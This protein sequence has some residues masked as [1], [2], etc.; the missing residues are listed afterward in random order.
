MLKRVVVTGLGCVTPLGIS[1]PSTWENLIAGACGISRLESEGIE[2]LPCQI[3]G[4][5][6]EFD[7]SK[8]LNANERRSANRTTGFAMSA[9]IEAT[10]Q[11]SLD[12]TDIDCDR[13]GVC[14]GSSLAGFMETILTAR[15]VNETQKRGYRRVS[16]FFV[17]RILDNMAAGAIAMRLGLLGPNHSCG[18]ACT[19]GAHS[20]GDGYNLIRLGMADVM[21]AGS[22]EACLHPLA[23]SGFS[24]AK[25]LC[26]DSNE[27]PLQSSRPFDESRS[28]FVMS[29]GAA[30]LVLEEMEHAVNR[31]AQIL[32]EVAGY[33]LSADAHH[34][35]APH[36]EGRG[37]LNA[38][39][40]ALQDVKLSRVSYINAH[41]TSTPL[42]DLAEG[43]A[44]RK[45]FNLDHEGPGPYVS[46]SKGSL[47]HLLGGAGS[48]E[49]LVCVQSIVH[50]TVPH[51]LNLVEPCCELNHVTTPIKD[52]EVDHV[53]TNSFGFGGTNASLLFKRFS[54]GS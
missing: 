34:I 44:I 15:S 33:G 41:A 7:E 54:G 22:A 13:A 14:F 46:S 43:T 25:A 36:P 3:G 52:A 11:A 45:I 39:R 49:A 4:S 27:K 16:P 19:T 51:T 10:N 28:G 30:V 18:T 32:A 12:F 48:V 50:Q 6:K 23:M 1:A 31:G 40:G 8:V 24:Q 35:T 26:T 38:M 29:E 21:L 37:A 42:G 2:H 9:A 53:M 5:V 20:V 47:G 17:P